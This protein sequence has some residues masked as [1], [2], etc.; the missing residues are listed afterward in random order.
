MTRK[1]VRS[2]VAVAVLALLPACAS[3]F[4][5]HGQDVRNAWENKL[6]NAHRRWDKYVLGLDWDDPYIDWVDESYATGPA[7]HH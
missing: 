1:S 7:H 4:S 6:H 5:D 2:I 3:P